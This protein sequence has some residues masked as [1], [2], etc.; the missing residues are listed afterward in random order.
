MAVLTWDAAASRLYHTGIDKCVLYPIDASG[1]YPLGVAWNGITGVT[2]SPSGAEASPLYADNIKYLNLISAE[3]FGGT[4]EAY[5]YPDEWAQ[6]DGSLS[7]LTGM[8]VGQQSRKMF[9]LAYRTLL[10]NDAEGNDYGYL[11]HL[12]YGCLAAPSERANQTINDSPEAVTFSWTFT[13]TPVAVTGYKP[14]SLIIVNSKDSTTTGLAAL[15]DELFGT[16]AE[17]PNLPLPD[18]VLTFLQTV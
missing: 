9:G 2:E 6:C 3:E 10:G 8:L 18:D 5:M 11:L 16:A 15:E 7:P 13:T 4:I 17:A 1:A 14:T 12:I